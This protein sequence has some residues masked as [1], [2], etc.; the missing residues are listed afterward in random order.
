MAGTGG[1]GNRGGSG[2]AGG[3]GGAAGGGTSGAGGTGG[4]A[5]GTAGTGS[6]GSSGMLAATPPMGWNSWNLFQCN[7]SE[8]LI[9]G[10]ADAI[11]S[12][13]MKDVGYQ[14]VNLDDCWM[15]G[16]DRAASCAGTPASFR[17][18]FPRSPTTFT[19][20]G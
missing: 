9:K 3:R 7:I 10:I 1:A 12:S 17:A 5:G 14:Y 11:V 20:R 15:D 13:G 4:A 19:A 2:G 18:G 8:S 16:R 6:A